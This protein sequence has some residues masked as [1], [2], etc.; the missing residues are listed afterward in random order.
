M[1]QFTLPDDVLD[2]EPNIHPDAFIAKGAQVMGNVTLEKDASVWYNAVLRGDINRI[3]VGERTNIQDCCLIHL[4]N[5]LP[6]LIAND[7]TVGHSAV[8][9]ACEIEEGCLIGIG[10]IILSGAKIGRGSIIGAGAVVLEGQVIPPSS[11][12]VGTPAK[13]IRQTPDDTVDKQIQWA[14]KYVDLSR[15][16]KLK[17]S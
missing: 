14:Q 9:H 2:A 4:E 10:A 16:H 15:I 17:N 7:V 13:V 6:C 5:E 11:L 12:V 3:V 8:L 1:I